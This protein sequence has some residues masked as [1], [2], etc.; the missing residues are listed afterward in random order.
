MPPP[1]PRRAK[2]FNSVVVLVIAAMM[3]CG[4]TFVGLGVQTA[5]I[6][7]AIGKQPVVTVARAQPT[8]DFTF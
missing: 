5:F 1:P 4:G 3:A 2:G 7:T 6:S 8:G